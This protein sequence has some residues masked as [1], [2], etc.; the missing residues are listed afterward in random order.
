MIINPEWK[1]EETVC[2]PNSW[3][4]FNPFWS[5]GMANYSDRYFPSRK[6]AQEECDR[7][8]KRER[9]SRDSVV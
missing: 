6:L 7:R 8:N 2:F 3:K 1:V 9:N 5:D 4:I